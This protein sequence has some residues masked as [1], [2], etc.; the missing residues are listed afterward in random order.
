MG[1]LAGRVAGRA[2]SGVGLGAGIGLWRTPDAAMATGEAATLAAVQSAAL[3]T[4]S[5][6][7]V[8][9]LLAV[10]AGTPAAEEPAGVVARALAGVLVEA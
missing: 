10:P 3:L 5:G 7:A 4:G 8:R 6:S 2:A 1:R 9:V